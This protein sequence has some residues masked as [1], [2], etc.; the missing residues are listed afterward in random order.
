MADE[1]ELLC[2][3]NKIKESLVLHNF[4]VESYY[5]IDYGLQF[6]ISIHDWSGKLRLYQNKKGDI[7]IDYSQ[8]KGINAEIIQEIIDNRNIDLISPSAFL[9]HN[10][11]GFPI[12]GTD[13]SGKGDYFGPLVIASIYVDENTAKYLTSCGVKDSKVLSD[14][15]NLELSKKIVEACKGQF[16]IIEISPG[17]Y[18][19]LYDKF[20]KEGK[21]LN[22]LLAWGHAKAIEEILVYKDCQNALVDQFADESVIINKLQQRGKQLNLIQKHKAEENIAVAAAS[23]LARARYLERL[24]ELTKLYKIDFPK[25]SSEEVNRVAKVFIERYGIKSLSQV[26]KIH[27]K[28]TAQVLSNATTDK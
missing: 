20:K 23:V 12:I 3:Y 24:S 4:N 17:K 26:A 15:K 19:I 1:K 28:T 21:N 11:L 27:F 6:N 7:K 18:N 13:E 22:V 10:K 9:Q 14:F 25:G 16:V 8:L 5:L 2:V